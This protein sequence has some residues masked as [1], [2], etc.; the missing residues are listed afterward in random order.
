MIMV[1]IALFIFV[2]FVASM[3]VMQQL[4]VVLRV[5]IAYN[6]VIKTKHERTIR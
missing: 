6:G 3:R 4:L 2:E 1:Y 5:G